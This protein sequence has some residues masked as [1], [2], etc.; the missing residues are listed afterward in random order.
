MTMINKQIYIHIPFCDSKCYYCNFCSSNYNKE[1]Q[2]KYF[3]KL[4]EEIKF[5]SNKYCNISS[6]FIGGGTP[7]SVNEKYI[8]EVI[9]N[10]RKSFNINKNAEITIEANPCSITEKKLRSYLNAGINRISFGVQ[11]LNNKCL[12]IIGRKHTKKQAIKAIKLAKKCGFNNI[13]CDILIGIPNQNYLKIKN[14][15]K[16]LI[17]LKISHFSCYM[18]INEKDTILTNLILKKKVK[19]IN[20]DKCVSFYNKAVKLLCKNNFQRYEIS[21]F[22]KPDLECKHNIGYWILTEYY[23]FGL[24]A[25]SYIN[26]TRYSNTHDMQKYLSFNFNYKKDKLSINEQIEEY[27]MLSLRTSMGINIAK[28]NKL[29]YDILNIKKK[30]IK[31]LTENKFINVCNS[32]IKVCNSKYGVINQIILKLLP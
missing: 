7:S 4:N 18:L 10:I 2:K 31:L 9:N 27:I 6:I 16:K 23:G 15:I 3:K 26:N 21:N 8:I 5:N 17:K 11:T 32:T 22:S 25:H 19:A 20:E 28:L 14:T 13:N 29:G 30:E 1:I 12:T 24:S